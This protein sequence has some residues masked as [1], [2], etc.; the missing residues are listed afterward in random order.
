M[1]GRGGTA[2]LLG[3]EL[4]Q[5]E[6]Y[7]ALLLVLRGSPQVVVLAGDAGVGKTTLVADLAPRAEELG[8]VVAVGHCLDIEAGI[9]FGPVI[10]AVSTLVAGIGDLDARPLARRMRAFLDPTTPGTAEQRNL[11]DDLR[12]AILEAAASGPVLLVLEDVHWADAST[13]DLAVALSRTAR[14]RLL[15]VLSVRTDDLHRRHPARKALAEIGRVSGGRRL[16]LGPLDEDSIAGIVASV[17]G[18]DPDPAL[19]RSVLERSEGIPLYAEEIAAAG[20]GGM[21]DP[22]SDLFLARVDAM[23]AGPRSLARTASV[24]GSRVEVE[25]LADVVDV[26]REQLDDFLRDLVD[27]NILHMA[28]G[29]LVFRHGLLRE[30]VY[31]DLLPDERTRRHAAFGAVLQARVDAETDPGMSLLGRLAFHWTA[32]SDLPRALTSSV[33]AGLAAK[34]V[35]ASES[36]T[37]L[38]RALSLWDRVPDAEGLAGHPQPELVV[39]LAEAANDQGDKERWH[40]LV[41]EAVGLL[42]PDTEPL[43]ASRVYSALGD[44]YLFTDETVGREEA[45]RLAIQYAGD[46][47]SEE[48]AHALAVQSAYLLGQHDYIGSLDSAFGAA[49]TARSVGATEILAE[50]LRNGGIAAS[51]LGR[52][53]EAIALHKESV[54]VSR[55][56]GRTG[57]AIRDLGNLAWDHMVAGQVDGGMEVARQGY[58]EGLVL[59]LPVQAA[60]CG[61]Q[62]QTAMT[63]QGRLEES[64]L[65]LGKLRDLGIPAYRWRWQRVELWLARGEVEAAASLLTENMEGL[66]REAVALA[67]VQLAEMRDELP[68]AVEAASTHLAHGDISHS[69]TESAGAARIGFQALA[70]TQSMP[71]AQ[72]N[73]LRALATRHLSIAQ[74]GLTDEWRAS[75]DGVQLA[76]A[77]A[78]AARVARRPAITEFRAAAELAAP[79][80]NFFALEPRLDLA[81][82]LLAHGGRDEGREILVDCWTSAR[83]MGAR[84]LERRAFRLATR[85]RVPLPESESTEGPLSRLTP[86]EREVLEQLAKGATNKVIASVLV[87][88]AKTVSV[89]VSNILSKLDVE[90]RGAAAALARNLIPPSHE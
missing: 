4:E 88:S 53:E 33:R 14:G 38:E 19:V 13:R 77:E 40:A 15:F 57:R 17:S 39:M 18:A 83:D 67:K 16:D 20:S 10:E 9:S 86:R 61:E 37:H 23:D 29:S 56:A 49:D 47:P 71:R 34:R 6:L 59:G 84:A 27:A 32:A 25:T 89:H 70:L 26:D 60:M 73:D 1:P 35:G 74:A 7:D 2:G 63:W 42:R 45:V 52:C 3:R 36:L 79:F 43:L 80:G 75:Y 76:L 48:L 54:R 85:T 87:I 62:M 44:C 21:S 46:G 90:N 11:L 72:T 55:Q 58:E 69:P 22:L 78:Y 30:A 24:D 12:M 28:G 41:R 64:E 81:Q 31:D 66:P 65:L 8:F 82:E 51:A 68:L 5:A 50:A